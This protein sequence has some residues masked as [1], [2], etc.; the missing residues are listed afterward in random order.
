MNLESYRIVARI[1]KR[2]NGEADGLRDDGKG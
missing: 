2:D 1:S